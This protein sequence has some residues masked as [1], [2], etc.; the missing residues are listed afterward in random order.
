MSAGELASRNLLPREGRDLRP[1][2]SAWTIETPACAGVPIK[3]AYA[4]LISTFT[5]AARSSFIS[6][7]TVAALGCTMSSSRL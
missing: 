2:G 5:P 3:P 6:A 7:S 1:M 4:S